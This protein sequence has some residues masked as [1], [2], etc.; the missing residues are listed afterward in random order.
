MVTYMFL[1]ILS[2]IYHT[3][4]YLNNSNLYVPDNFIR[5][6]SKNIHDNASK[7]LSFFATKKNAPRRENQVFIWELKFIQV[8]FYHVF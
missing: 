2:D 3:Q 4:N 6:M 1:M 8:D 5:S 7:F